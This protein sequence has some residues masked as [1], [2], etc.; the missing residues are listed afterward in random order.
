MAYPKSLNNL[1]SSF[2]D[3]PG[4]GEKTAERMAL[5]MLNFEK[6]KLDSFAKAIINVKDKI[7]RCSIC[8]NLTEDEICDICSDTS[9]DENTICVVEDVKNVMLFEKN[10]L[11]NGK[12]H[13]LN[14]LISPVDGIDP[15]DINIQSLL[16]R[17]EKE[18]TKEIIIAVKPSLEGEATALYISKKLEGNNVIVS[19]IAHG[20]PMGAD[21]EYIDAMTLETALFDRKKV[22]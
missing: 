22:S 18:N 8:N 7:K 10:G 1:I 4:V 11:F 21:M 3:L 9:R 6:N 14:G 13:V 16:D 15:S 5:T 12:Y 19:K 20:V 2:K 17:V